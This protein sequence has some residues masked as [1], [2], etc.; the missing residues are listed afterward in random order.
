M[1]IDHKN[2]KENVRE[3]LGAIKFNGGCMGKIVKKSY[4]GNKCFFK[5]DSTSKQTRFS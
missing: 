2:K 3:G 4:N 5:H 1:W